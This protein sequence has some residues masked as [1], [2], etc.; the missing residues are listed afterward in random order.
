MPIYTGFAYDIYTLVYI[1]SVASVCLFWRMCSEIDANADKLFGRGA[2][3][4]YFKPGL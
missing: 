3:Y 1:S 2:K 4:C